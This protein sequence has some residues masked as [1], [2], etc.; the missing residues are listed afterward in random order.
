[1]INCIG[2]WPAFEHGN[3]FVVQ[4]FTLEIKFFFLCRRASPQIA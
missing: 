1:M 2:N 4:Y 3:V